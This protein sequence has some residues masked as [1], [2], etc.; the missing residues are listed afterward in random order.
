MPDKSPTDPLAVADD[1]KVT[2]VG[3]RIVAHLAAGAPKEEAAAAAGIGRSTLYLWL[4]V[5][6][7]AASAVARAELLGQHAP[8]LDD[9]T[10]ACMEF[11]AAVE[12]AMAEWEVGAVTLLERLA[13]GGLPVTKVVEV[14]ENNGGQLTTVTRT[15]TTMTT[16][17]DVRAL[18]WKL[19]RAR[20]TRWGPPAIVVGVAGTDAGVGAAAAGPARAVELAGQVREFRAAIEAQAT[21][22]PSD[23]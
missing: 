16:L 13:R 4:R 17:P 1:G 8:V 12:R 10:T 18:T 23:G 19:E 20:P 21:E 2:T 7:D 3:D 15:T 6:A 14:Q 11:A 5:G 9:R 22:V